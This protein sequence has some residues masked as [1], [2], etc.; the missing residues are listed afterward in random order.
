MNTTRF[1]TAAILG[2]LLLVSCKNDTKSND[3]AEVST[4]ENVK[5]S[6][7]KP[8]KKVKPLT[9]EQRRAAN[10]V[11]RKL[12]KT[13]ESK[14]F[15]RALVTA[16]LIGEL[17]DLETNY[18]IFAAD[19]DAFKVLEPGQNV[20]TDPSRRAEL[21]ALLSNHIVKG[22]FSSADLAQEIK[23]NGKYVLTTIHDKKLT[24]SM[25]NDLMVV[26][27]ANKSSTVTL[28]KTD[29]KGTNGILHIVDGLLK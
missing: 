28:G 5:V 23:K 20:L 11:Q 2:A 21:V 14:E 9:Q 12:M 13:K 22:S 10:G 16:E 8:E 25:K 1:F 4:T 18:T 7:K 6:E 3:G 27:N 26:T 24:V 17:E 19:N 15:T 29:I